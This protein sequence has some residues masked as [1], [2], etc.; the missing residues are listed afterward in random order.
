MSEL[1]QDP[2]TGTW[3]VIAPHRADRPRDLVRDPDEAGDAANCPFCAGN[4]RET[5]PTRSEASLPGEFGWTV[6]VVENRYPALEV[7]EDSDGADDLDAP[8]PYRATGGFGVHELIVETPRHGEGLADYP[9]E[10]LALLADTYA[11]RLA[12]W[13]ED[14]RL[15]AALLFR[16]WGR[17]AGASL[18]HAHTQLVALPR[19]PDALVRE[20]GNFSQAASGSGRCPLCEALSADDEGGR[21]VFDDGIVAVHSP[22]AAPIPYS[23]RIAP[24]GCSLSLAD[25]GAEERASFGAAM[26]AA[27]RALR[28]AFGDVAFN[29]FVHVAPYTVH[30][31]Q[32]L[33]FH[34]HAE[35]TPHTF[36]HAGFEWGSGTHINVIDPDDAA[37]VLRDGLAVS[38]DG[39]VASSAAQGRVR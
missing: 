10:H 6:R 3:T 39:S 1:R 4:E 17:F 26:G 34:W 18:S 36:Q 33:P 20:L 38:G 22:Y 24:R 12:G 9:A 13:R 31:I 15:A 21:A 8:P 2:V 5:P 37:R 29:L 16:N 19:V 32:G 28:G 14:S 27:A 30:R 25:A 23:M 35:V 7:P 11:T